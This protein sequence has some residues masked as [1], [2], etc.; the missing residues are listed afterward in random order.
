MMA[1]VQ[2]LSAQELAELREWLAS[3]SEPGDLLVVRTRHLLATIDDRDHT[4]AQQARVIQ[5]VRDLCR[6]PK[7][8]VR[9]FCNHADG[10]ADAIP[11]ATILAA[12]D[13]AADGGKP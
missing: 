6:D 2:A 4:I 11:V 8:W 9:Y 5:A 13:A 12:L 10:D 1:D 3:E 7:A